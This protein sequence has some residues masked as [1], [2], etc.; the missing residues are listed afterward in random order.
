MTAITVQTAF[1]NVTVYTVNFKNKNYSVRVRHQPDKDNKPI[2][3]IKPEIKHFNIWR[4]I[5]NEVWNHHLQY[6]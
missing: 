3:R 4:N 6:G 2:M 1:A 5:R